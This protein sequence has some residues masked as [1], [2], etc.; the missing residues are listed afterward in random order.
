MTRVTDLGE[1]K[2]IERLVSL[3]DI[4]TEDV[5]ARY[6]DV[7]YMKSPKKSNIVLHADMLVGKTD[8]PP[9][10]EHYQ[11]GRKVIIQNVSD[12]IVKGVVPSGMIVSMALPG[13]ML[14]EEFDAL[15]Q[16]IGDTAKGF[17]IKYIGGDL[18]EADDLVIDI[19]LVGFHDN[20]IIPRKG[21]KPGQVIVTTGAFGFT[22][23]GLHLALNGLVGKSKEKYRPVIDAVYKPSLNYKAI[24]NIARQPG[25]IASID[26]SDGLAA[27]FFDLMDVNEYGFLIDTLPV[28][29]IIQEFALEYNLPVDD[30]LFNGGEE[31][32]AIFVVDDKR[33]DEIDF[34]ARKAGY[35][36][37]KIG[38]VIEEKKLLYQERGL[39][40]KKEIKKR[41][42][43]HFSPSPRAP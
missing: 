40:G 4:E 26:S 18:N 12:F 39:K 10:M 13:T 3:V 30:L 42:F 33:F 43:E 23:A 29:P 11:V 21:I 16:G 7:F 15:M 19:T 31:F 6:D 2:L 27:C 28:E 32:H 41:G 25:V 20:V 22:S 9:G 24:L 38:R 35:Y 37:Q 34:F 14:V 5:L 17:G 1:K 36:V 8:V